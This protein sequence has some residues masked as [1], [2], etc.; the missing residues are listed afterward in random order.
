MWYNFY[1]YTDPERHNAQ[2]QTQTDRQM[3]ARQYTVNSRSYCLTVRSAK[4][5]HE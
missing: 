1:P 5:R 2:R 4:N 3:D